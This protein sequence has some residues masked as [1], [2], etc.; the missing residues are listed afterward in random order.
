MPENDFFLH[1][2]SLLLK[3]SISTGWKMLEGTALNVLIDQF[4][5]KLREDYLS[6]TPAEIEY[7]FRNTS[8]VKNFG[9]AFNLQ[10]VDKVLVPYMNRRANLREFAD[11]TFKE[12]PS[13]KIDQK[14][15]DENAYEYW[16]K[17]IL[18]GCQV[19]YIPSDLVDVII[20]HAN[21]KPS[22]KSMEN[23][24]YKAQTHILHDYSVRLTSTDPK[25]RLGDFLELNNTIA[26]LKK[27]PSHW[28]QLPIVQRFA[29]AFWAKHYFIY[30]YGSTNATTGNK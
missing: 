8:D 21:V 15:S 6:L 27:E 2:K 17:E 24:I 12:L 10:L 1:V 4:S 29:K 28:E 11:N 23:S 30:K 7:A 16:K 20:R 3:I 14:V 25:K 18:N 19:G 26:L 9:S 13:A 5:K 22:P